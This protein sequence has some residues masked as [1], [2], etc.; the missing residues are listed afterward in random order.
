MI[1]VPLANGRYGAFCVVDAQEDGCQFFVVD[2][3]WDAVPA[4]DAVVRLRPMGP[5]FGENALLDAAVW[6]GWFPGPVAADFVTLRRVELPASLLRH[7]SAEGTMIFQNAE[8]FRG[9]LYRQWRW[10]HDREA[11]QAEWSAA[12]A[13]YEREQARRAAERKA[14]LSLPKMLR[15]RPFT[16][17]REQWPAHAVRAV[18]AAFRTAVEELIAL[19]ATAPR[20]SKEAI[21][22]RLIDALNA[23]YDREGC[24][25]TVEA[26]ELIERI[27]EMAGLVGLD[28]EN[29]RL[30]APR[31]W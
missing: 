8:H 20:R 24:I 16:H 9:E 11:L 17:W 10:L 27:E 18:H 12:A 30:T 19:G 14:T 6:K 5:P 13:R 25:E 28:N 1:A 21:F 23:I 7:G 26:T 15:E 4:Q 31:T 3:F 22:R 2:E 29:E